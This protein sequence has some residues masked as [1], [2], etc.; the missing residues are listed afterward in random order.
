[1]TSVTA[2]DTDTGRMVWTY[3][4]VHHDLWDYDTNAAPTLVDIE[5]D[6]RT[7]PALVQTSK[8]GFLYVL[9]RATGAPVYPIEERPVPQTDV[10]GETSSPTQPFVALP[11]RVVPD[12]WPGVY[13]LADAVSAG[14]CS[15]KAA[16]LRDEGPFT[17]PSVG[18]SLVWPSFIGGI[19][20]GGGAVD[21][22]SGI[23]VVNYSSVAEIYRLVARADYDAADKAG[24]ETGG[25]SPMQ[26]APFGIEL[27][28]FLNPLGMPCWK[29]PYGSMAAY[30]LK[31]GAQL[32]DVPFGQVQQYGFYMPESWGSVTIGGPVVTA[33]GL[34]FA[35]ASMD[36]RVRAL[37]LA[38][39]EVL[40]KGLVSAPAVAL[41]A[42]YAYEGRQY[43][44]F[45]AGGN[46]I[47]S[48]RVSDEVVAFALPR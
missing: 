2:L 46:S 44:V 18:G 25:F 7:I 5:K 4:L 10:P 29:P 1:V 38:T 45:V 34:I 12:R 47:L 9:D 41:P 19:E 6:G 30:D 40:W 26:G 11:E 8:Q 35:G 32:W 48:P 23:F 15:R 20:W 22:R 39:G 17:P 14:W 37:D 33:S 28:T 36:S 31:T 3:Q 16:T 24:G 42:V 27:T 13:P 21:P 43:V